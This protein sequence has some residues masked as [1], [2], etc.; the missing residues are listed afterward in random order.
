MRVN[1]SIRRGTGALAA[2]AAAGALAVPAAH[3]DTLS[4]A[5]PTPQAIAAHAE[6]LA[7]VPAPPAGAGT[8][9]VIDTGVSPLPD[10]AGQIVERLAIDGGDPGDIYH[11]ADNPLSGHGSFV[12]GTIASQ[13]DGQGSAGIWPAAKII[14][15][16]V[17]SRSD[18]GASAADYRSAIAECLH[19]DRNVKVITLSIAGA[20][21]TFEELAVLENRVINA[22]DNLGM[23]VV[24]GAGNS[25]NLSTV[26]YPARFPAVF[27]V[28][29]SDPRGAFCA[30]SDR[31]AGLDLATLGCNTQVPGST[32]PRGALPARPTPLPPWRRSCLRCG[33]IAQ[34]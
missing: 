20:S 27:A 21:A 25:G 32:A 33:P 10:T 34:P 28:G 16:R 30:F 23:N 24:A 7:Q 4:D 6:F 17:F 11:R 22:H 3:A 15:V 5:Y 13:V 18:A 26:S 29:A 31:G 9:C 8:V 12:A 1:G 14:S 2:F 19:T